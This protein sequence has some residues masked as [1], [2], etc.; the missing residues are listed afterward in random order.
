MRLILETRVSAEWSWLAVGGQ[1]RLQKQEQKQIQ[2]ATAN[3][4]TVQAEQGESPVSAL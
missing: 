4:I 2:R 1:Q 3:P